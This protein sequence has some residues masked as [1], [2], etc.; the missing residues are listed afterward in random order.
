VTYLLLKGI[1]SG[2]MIVGIS[3]LAKRYSLLSA[4]LASLP[5]TSLMAFIWIYLEQRDTKAISELSLEIVWLVVPSLA[6]FFAL[7]LLLG[8]KVNFWLSLLISSM[9]TALCYALTL[10][11]KSWL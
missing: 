11:I 6:F 3:E 2:G 1:L 5:I 4:L 9:I 8:G 7:N 10:Q